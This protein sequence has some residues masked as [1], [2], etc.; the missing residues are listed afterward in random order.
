M[1]PETVRRK[2]ELYETRYQAAAIDLA[3]ICDSF[4]YDLA[5]LRHR[6]NDD[7]REMVKVVAERLLGAGYPAE[8]VCDIIH[9]SKQSVKA[10]LND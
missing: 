2:Q 5:V 4:K 1:N 8:L 7:N 10:A 9:K 6:L 3:S